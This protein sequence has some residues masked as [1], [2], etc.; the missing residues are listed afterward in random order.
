MVAAVLLLVAMAQE[1]GA[2]GAATPQRAAPAAAVTSGSSPA[3]GAAQWL[4]HLAQHHGHTVGRSDPRGVTLHVLALMQAAAQVDPTLPAPL[5]WQFDLLGR[6]DRPQQASAALKQYVD[7]NPRDETAHLLYIAGE[8]D[9]TQT[10]E[11]RAEFLRQR[12]TRPNLPKSVSSDLYRRLAEYHHE[13]HEIEE[14]GRAVENALRLM[15]SN[16]AA[17]RLSYEMFGETEPALQRVELALTL[18]SVNPGQV[19]LLWE[20]GG[21]LDSLSLHREAQEWYLRAIELHQQMARTPISAEQWLQLAQSYVN[22][23]DVKPAQEAAG[24]ALAADANCDRARLLLATLGGSEKGTGGDGDLEALAAKFATQAD[25]VIAERNIARAAEL[26]WFFAYHHPDAARAIKL[27]QIATRDPNASLLA[28]RALGYALVQSGKFDEALG[29]LQPLAARDQLAAV[30]AAKALLGLQ[31]EGDAKTLL[32]K[33]A[34]LGFSGAGFDEVCQLLAK[35]GEKPPMKPGHEK[36]VQAVQRFD[37]RVFDYF[38]RPGEF[39]KLSLATEAAALPAVGPWRVKVRLE[40]VGPF[41]ITVGEEMMAQPLVLF[42]VQLGEQKSGRYE[43]YHQV[44]LNRRPVLV[45]GD[46]I[47]ETATLD[48]GPL[49]EQLIRAASWSTSV[50]IE[51]LFDPVAT[52][53]GY[54][55]GPTTVAAT[56]LELKRT[57]LPRERGGIKVILARLGDA[58]VETRLR[59]IDEIGAILAEMT[60]ESSGNDGA[61]ARALRRRLVQLA[62]D[63]EWT[64]RARAIEAL[65]WSPQPEETLGQLAPTLKDSQFV[66]QMMAVRFFA[67]QQGAKFGKVLE[68]MADEASEPA[69]RLLARSYVQPGGG[70]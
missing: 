66:V 49:R 56:P 7:L 3:T 41:P 28:Q 29:V 20:L 21:M 23:K 46:V 63:A 8:L 2:D 6:I 19:N 9:H 34:M 18:I 30:G 69:V 45:P 54:A 14:A 36:I 58:N 12:L 51:A 1:P 62:G 64:V 65:R 13:R 67:Q 16:I 44:L 39:L 48:V 42:S 24:K 68:R 5:L 25:Q 32:H 31:R 17:R 52:A 40:N 38:K 47:E 43:N 26:A 50:R 22:S 4:V 35:F 37:R 10:A 61:E 70:E 53:S 33:A 59:T 57:G 15:P 27:A 55:S 60:Q 11:A